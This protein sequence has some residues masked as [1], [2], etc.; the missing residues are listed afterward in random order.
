MTGIATPAPKSF[1]IRPISGGT[2]IVVESAEDVAVLASLF[3]SNYTFT[4]GK[5]PTAIGRRYEMEIWFTDGVHT[6]HALYGAKDNAPLLTVTYFA[7]NNEGDPGVKTIRVDPGTMPSSL[8][9]KLNSI[10]LLSSA[11]PQTDIYHMLAPGSAAIK[12]YDSPLTYAQAV[13]EK[14]IG[15][16]SSSIKSQH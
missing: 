16:P 5:P 13:K 4:K 1:R 2:T 14:S 12:R 7:T 10:G 6:T 8:R 9:T 11:S 3:R 15:F